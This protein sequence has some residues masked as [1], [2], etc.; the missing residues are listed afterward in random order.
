MSEQAVVRCASC[1]GY[2]WHTDEFTGEAED[3]GW[4]GG[5]GYVY[6]G[7]DG[8]QQPI[9]E[10]DYG[11]VADAVETLERDRMR[12]LGYTGDAK[13]PWEQ[14]VR[15]GTRGGQHPSERDV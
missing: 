13:P 6:Q 1:D 4:C 12:E 10:Q 8:A 5:I 2:G 11:K 7:A 15:K 9:P 14:D 3:C